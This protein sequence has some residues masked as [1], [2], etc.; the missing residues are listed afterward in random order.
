MDLSRLQASADPGA[1][2]TVGSAVATSF[3]QLE[4]LVRPGTIVSLTDASG[5]ELAGRIETLSP[6]ALS[7]AIGGT[8]RDFLET[9]G[10]V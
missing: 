4:V 2:G 7:L 3:E 1:D 9:A 6:S 8:R 5:S 10:L